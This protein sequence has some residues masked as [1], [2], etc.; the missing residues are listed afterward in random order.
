[1]GLGG[2]FVPLGGDRPSI[3]AHHSSFKFLIT[4]ALTLFLHGTIA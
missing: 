3:T 1:V 4:F 2:G